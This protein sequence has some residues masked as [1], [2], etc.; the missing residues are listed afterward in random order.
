MSNQKSAFPVP[1]DTL[2]VEISTDCG[3]NYRKIYL[4]SGSVLATAT[5]W[6]SSEQWIP[7]SITGLYAIC[8]VVL[9]AKHLQW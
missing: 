1:N 2:S 9:Y 8:Q 4:K 6:G 3:L 5:N 7:L